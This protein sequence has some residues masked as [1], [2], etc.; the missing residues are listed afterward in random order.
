MITLPYQHITISS[1]PYHFPESTVT[2]SFRRRV[3]RFDWNSCAASSHVKS[4]QVHLAWLLRSPLV[5]AYRDAGLECPGWPC[6]FL[7][8]DGTRPPTLPALFTPVSMK[9]VVDPCVVALY[10]VPF[11]VSRG[12][13]LP[14][15]SKPT[16]SNHLL[17]HALWH[18]PPWSMFRVRCV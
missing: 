14:R 5:P 7:V 18:W 17:C 11:V 16:R 15:T 9:A 1:P 8:A 4:S 3:H 13:A 6:T 2:D 12:E 10:G